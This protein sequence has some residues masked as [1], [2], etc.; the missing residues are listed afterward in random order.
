MLVPKRISSIRVDTTLADSTA[1]STKGMSRGHI[2]VPAESTSMT[3]IAW[4]G[5]YDNVTFAVL[6]N[7]SGSAVSNSSI[8]TST[9]AIHALP[10]EVLGLPWVKG[11]A[12]GGD[13]ADC[14][15]TGDAESAEQ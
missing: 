9:E 10:S 14:V 7:S 3:A 8:S 5:S 11:V 2:H 4:Y 13:A 6:K 1:F 12:T 15:V